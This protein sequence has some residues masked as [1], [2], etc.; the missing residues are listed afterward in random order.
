MTPARDKVR[1]TRAVQRTRPGHESARGTKLSRQHP[2]QGPTGTKLS[3]HAHLKAQPVQNS[4]GTLKFNENRPFLTSRENL[5]PFPTPHHR[6]GR[7]FSRNNT[8]LVSISTQLTGWSPLS[9]GH[10]TNAPLS[11]ALCGLLAAHHDVAPES[12]GAGRRLGDWTLPRH[13]QASSQQPT[14]RTNVSDV[15]HRHPQASSQQK[16]STGT[17][18][19]LERHDQSAHS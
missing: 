17:C 14:T 15:R 8:T 4:P 5:F 2:P 9:P 6:A 10:Q 12:A 13:P 18:A 19:E 7:I 16:L 1:P 3:R 11:W